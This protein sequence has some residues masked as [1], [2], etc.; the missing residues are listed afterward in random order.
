MCD[1]W[2]IKDQ[3]TVYI[4]TYKSLFMKHICMI[5]CVYNFVYMYTRNFV[6]YK[7]HTSMLKTI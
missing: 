4:Y 3:R 2:G 7:I 1:I 5:M 6:I